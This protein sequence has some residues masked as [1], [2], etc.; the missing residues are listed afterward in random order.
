MFKVM[1]RGWNKSVRNVTAYIVW[2]YGLLKIVNNNIGMQTEDLTSSTK[3]IQMAH[4]VYS[5]K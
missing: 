1:H 2:I 3:Y 5:N 4:H